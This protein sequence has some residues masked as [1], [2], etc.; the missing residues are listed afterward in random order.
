MASLDSTVQAEFDKLI[1]AVHAEATII[2]SASTLLNGLTAQ[3][4]ALKN[5]AV[6]AGAPADVI[7]AIDGVMT[8]VQSNSSALSAAVVANT[9]AA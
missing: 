5:T 9:P 6:T 3:I 7:A 8:S 2:G 1:A 4:A